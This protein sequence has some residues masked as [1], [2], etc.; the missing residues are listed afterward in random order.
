MFS[1]WD[2]VFVLNYLRAISN[3]ACLEKHCWLDLFPRPVPL[4][5]L[6]LSSLRKGQRHPTQG[7][8]PKPSMQSWFP[9]SSAFPH[10]NCHH[11]LLIVIWHQE[12]VFF[13]RS[14]LPPLDQTTMATFPDRSETVRTGSSTLARSRPLWSHP[15]LKVCFKRTPESPNSSVPKPCNGFL[16]LLEE[17][18]NF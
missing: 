10:P 15:T 14:P 11:V 6:I 4:S 3:L 7:I 8:S 12:P 5:P 16:S 2:R 1:C 13:S 18:T 9:L 17:N